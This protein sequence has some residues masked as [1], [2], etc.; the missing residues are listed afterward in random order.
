MSKKFD[1]WKKERD[2]M[3]EQGRKEIWNELLAET[4][5]NIEAMNELKPKDITGDYRLSIGLNNVDMETGKP[6]PKKTAAA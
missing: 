3:L 6:A 2:N 1:D 4:A 5:K